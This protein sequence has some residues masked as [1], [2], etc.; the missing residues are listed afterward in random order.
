MPDGATV[1]IAPKTPYEPDAPV[2]PLPMP[3]DSSLEIPNPVIVVEVL[4]P[5]SVKRDLSEKVA[6]YFKVPS[7]AHY[8]VAD[9]EE[10]EIIWHRRRAGG[11]LEEPVPMKEGILHR[12]PPGIELAVPDV[13]KAGQGPIESFGPEEPPR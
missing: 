3:E 5:S 8:L 10:M 7:I 4:S 9:P 13:F 6:G 12:E 1:R 11:G 2:G